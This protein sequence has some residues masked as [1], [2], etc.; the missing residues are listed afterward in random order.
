MSLLLYGKKEDV[1]KLKGNPKPLAW[2]IVERRYE[3][4]LVQFFS[5]TFHFPQGTAFLVFSVAVTYR[6]V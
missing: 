1:V 4:D 5:E 6:R 3:R 2:G